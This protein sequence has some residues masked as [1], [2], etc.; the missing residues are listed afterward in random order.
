MSIPP[1]PPIKPI[2]PIPSIKP[3][4]PIPKPTASLQAKRKYK[5][6]KWLKWKVNIHS[7]VKP[8]ELAAFDQPEM[9]DSS[10]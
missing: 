8:P 4:P 6:P 5:A 7:S 9:S 1:I 3:L 10:P 2:K